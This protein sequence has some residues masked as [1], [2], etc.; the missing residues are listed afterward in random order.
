MQ[1]YTK[2]PA[3]G[4][5]MVK[6]AVVSSNVVMNVCSTVVLSRMKKIF[7]EFEPGYSLATNVL[8]K[9]HQIY[10]LL[11]YLTNMSPSGTVPKK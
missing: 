11:P 9:L 4:D 1:K 3:G 10:K 2:C 8:F 5:S 6:S 7:E